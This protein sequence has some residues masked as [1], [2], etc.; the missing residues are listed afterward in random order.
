MPLR[1]PDTMGRRRV[2]AVLVLVLV[3][4]WSPVTGAAAGRRSSRVASV[5][6]SLRGSEFLGR[7][8]SEGELRA[9]AMRDFRARLRERCGWKFERG[10]SS[11]TSLWVVYHNTARLNES[12]LGASDAGHAHGVRVAGPE[13]FGECDF[14]SAAFTRVL[15]PDSFHQTLMSEHAALI[16]LGPGWH[17]PGVRRC[18]L[19]RGRSV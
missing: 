19:H 14:D 5:A 6:A 13:V 2:A 9:R 17:T 1:L 18:H 16:L 11:G 7:F 3:F 8:A 4:A 10:S 15:A 12:V